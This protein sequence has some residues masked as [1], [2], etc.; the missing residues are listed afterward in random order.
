MRA[1][2]LCASHVG[3]PE[4]MSRPAKPAARHSKRSFRGLWLALAPFALLLVY[5]SCLRGG[6][7]WD[8]GTWTVN[9][10]YY[11][12]NLR[13]LIT[14]WTDVTAMQQYFPVTATSFWLDWQLWGAWSLPY[15]VENVLLHAASALLLWRVLIQLRAPAATLAAA[16]FALHPMMVESVAWITERKN[17]LSLV[18]MLLALLTHPVFQDLTRMSACSGPRRWRAHAISA[19]LFVAAL[20]AKITA[21]VLPPALLVLVWWKKG[22][23]GWREHVRPILP[24]FLLALGPGLL[25]HWLEKSHVGA[26]GADFSLSIAERCVLAGKVFWHYPAKLL[27]PVDL[28]LFYPKLPLNASAPF[29]WT[30]FI[31]I[32]IAFGLLWRWRSRRAMR[33]VLVVALLYLGALFPVMGFLNVYGMLI[34]DVADR[35]CYVP[36]IGLIWLAAAALD[37]LELPRLLPW[38]LMPVLAMLTWQ[39]AAHYA[40]EDA[41]WRAAVQHNPDS[42]CVRNN[43]GSLLTQQKQFDEAEVHL[44]HS[45]Q[46]RPTHAEAWCNLANL[47]REEGHLERAFE[48]YREALRLRPDDY[49]DAHNNYGLTL[50]QTG[51]IEEGI[52]HF[53]RAIAIQPLHALA[54]NNLGN[55]LLHVGKAEQALSSY[56][57]AIE[58][59]PAYPD[60]HNY[61]GL[62]LLQLGRA[63]EALK[64]LREAVRLRPDYADAW[65][66][67]GH[68]RL[69]LQRPAEAIRDFEKAV[70]LKPEYARALHNLGLAHFMLGDVPRSIQSY[71]KA[72]AADPRQ[73]SSLNNLAWLLAT[74]AE[75]AHRDAKSALELAAQA[76]QLSAGRDATVLHTLAAAQ[77]ENGLFDEAVKSARQ[78]LDL[79]LAQNNATLAAATREQLRGYESR[80][81]FREP[82]PA[83]PR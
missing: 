83:P 54:H 39:H 29:E 48:A 25:V 42:W 64:V 71:E 37:K 7:I 27:W 9:S 8:D 70:E 74:S 1:A 14:I 13:G 53:R 2:S 69:Q 22:R 61:T 26:D 4:T 65:N 67:L 60:A 76:M 56:Q 18:F 72:L 50:M 82:A 62:A 80:Q 75:P 45:I 20:L 31:A 35:W 5:S 3:S 32:F 6:F 28:R 43:L 34:S 11:Y 17:T 49:P 57:R 63:E 58:I 10:A 24:L 21:C 30:G 77:A 15:H 44:R 12:Q 16:I 68:A 47:H 46:I 81:P 55:G 78:A 36:A 33:A 66:N 23:L 59:N 51:R 38:L 73:L 40:S 19:L 52:A 79:A 41:F